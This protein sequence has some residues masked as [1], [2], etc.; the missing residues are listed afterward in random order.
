MNWSKLSI[1]SGLLVIVIA[2]NINE[3]EFDNVELQDISPTI[4]APLGTFE[5]T[6]QELLEELDDE[7]IT[8]GTDDDQVILLTF[9]DSASFEVSDEFVRIDD[10]D[11]SGSV[12]PGITAVATTETIRIPF[13][14]QFIYEYESTTEERLDSVFYDNGTMEFRVISSC[15]C[16]YTYEFQILNTVNLTTGMP[17]TA[18]GS[19]IFDGVSSN[20]DEQ[21]LSLANF[22]TTLDNNLSEFVSVLRGEVVVRPGQELRIE[23]ELSFEFIYRDQ[24]F[25]AI[26]GFFGTDSITIDGGQIDIELFDE[27]TSAGIAFEGPSIRFDFE[28]KIGVPLGVLLDSV[29]GRNSSGD[30]LF[31][32]GVLPSN[33]QVIAFNEENIYEAATTSFEINPTNS[34]I[35]DVFGLAPNFISFP[36][37]GIS[38]VNNS[39]GFNYITD[40]SRIDAN[41]TFTLPMSFRLDDF[42]QQVDFDIEGSV[43]TDELDSAFLQIVT[44]N[45]LPFIVEMQ[46]A[47]NDSLGVELFRAPQTL[48]IEIPVYNA[49]GEIVSDSETVSRITLPPQGVEALKNGST[50]VIDL[51]MNSPSNNV[52]EFFPIL[53]TNSIRVEVGVGG[54]GTIDL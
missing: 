29:Y 36:I 7:N 54:S 20:V 40:S 17:L 48:V 23:D 45:N 51:V 47:I 50:M 8:I 24:N 39:D 11:G 15:E 19:I 52:N 13:E 28:N 43:D 16:D 10:V 34:N 42:T 14:Q 21:V 37:T 31:L 30:S 12:A 9:E 3:L 53:S 2:C 4:A 49:V 44:R 1:I 26:F 6:M 27:A 38:N 18:S 33:P 22:K 41:L 5:Y 25:D 32:S 46:V 35:R